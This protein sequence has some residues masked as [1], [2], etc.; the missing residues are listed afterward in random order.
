MSATTSLSTGASPRP[1]LDITATP[2]RQLGINTWCAVN[3]NIH[4]L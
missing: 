2:Q 4:P 1:T 3:V